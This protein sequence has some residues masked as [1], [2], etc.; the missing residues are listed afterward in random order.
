[1][2]ELIHC[3][4][5]QKWAI[6]YLLMF[7]LPMGYMLY[8]IGTLVQELNAIG[9]DETMTNM[10]L[11]M[12][13]PAAI[14]MSFSAFILV[15]RSANSL[16]QTTEAA[17]KLMDEFIPEKRQQRASGSM[18]EAQKI[19]SYVT[20]MIEEL[21]G[22]LMD[23]DRY[24]QD[25]KTANQKLTEIAVNDGLT[26]LYN[27]KHAMHILKFELERAIRF[28]H[29]LS[30][31]MID[32]DEFKKF[33]DTYGHPVGDRALKHVATILNDNIRNVDIAARYGGEEFMLII[34]ETMPT[35]T[36]EVGERIRRAIETSKFDVGGGKKVSMT[37][38]IG[39]SAYMG[40]IMTPE[41]LVSSADKNLY[42]AKRSGKNRVCLWTDEQVNIPVIGG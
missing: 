12:G 1:M 27:H 33:N 17:E 16:T 26:G 21:R 20:D 38:S 31:C 14:I 19:S 18:D 11:L 13:I 32:I 15:M 30:I 24:A 3:G 7:I 4:L 40:L 10:S 41:E 36:A 29:P 5:K 22:K 34:P 23:V 35:D 28:S 25:L 42:K 6:A 9:G 8:V 39:I 2:K 37:V